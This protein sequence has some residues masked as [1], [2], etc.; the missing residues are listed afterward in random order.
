VNREIPFFEYIRA[1]NSCPVG[2]IIK[3]DMIRTLFLAAMVM[4]VTLVTYGQTKEIYVNPNFQ[5]LTK[6]H[7]TIAILPFRATTKLTFA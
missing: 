7:K 4:V 5:Q 1:A 3:N 6:D 2:D